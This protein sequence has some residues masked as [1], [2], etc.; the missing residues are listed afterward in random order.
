MTHRLAALVALTMATPLFAQDGSEPGAARTPE[1]AQRFLTQLLV[2]EEPLWYSFNAYRAAANVS[3]EPRAGMALVPASGAIKT[4]TSDSPCRTRLTL[5][6]AQVAQR[7]S[8]ETTNLQ[9]E[10]GRT[11]RAIDWSKVEV[12]DK[13]ESTVTSRDLQ[14]A[15]ISTRSEYGVEMTMQGGWQKLR[16][17]LPAKAERDRLAFAAEF[18]K[19]SCELKS[20]TGF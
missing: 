9:I 10:G 20:D 3:D 19:T 14:G 15:V 12:I 6:Q 5:E 1:S 4:V 2:R 13:F 18:L 7:D 16:F 17:N 11:M 8:G